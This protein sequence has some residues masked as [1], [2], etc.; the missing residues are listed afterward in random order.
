MAV[1][2]AKRTQPNSKGWRSASR[3]QAR[4]EIPLKAELTQ[5][6]SATMIGVHAAGDGKP[7][8]FVSARKCRPIPAVMLF[9]FSTIGNRRVGT[10]MRIPLVGCVLLAAHSAVICAKA[11][12]D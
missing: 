9:N 4:G 5:D 7:E 12:N 3:Q 6:P 11:S 2:G 1:V 8:D 10:Q